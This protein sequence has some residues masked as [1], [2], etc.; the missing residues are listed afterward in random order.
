MCHPEEDYLRLGLEINPE[1]SFND[2]IKIIRE[3]KEY[4]LECEIE[5]SNKY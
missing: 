3:E 2:S 5:E 4:L 1:I